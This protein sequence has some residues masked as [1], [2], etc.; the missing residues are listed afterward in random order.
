MYYVL[1]CVYVRVCMYVYI[2]VCVCMYV[3]MYVKI[4][5]KS[6]STQIVTLPKIGALQVSWKGTR[7][8]LYLEKHSQQKNNRKQT[9][10]CMQQISFWKVN[11]FSASQKNI[12]LASLQHDN[13]L[14]RSQNHPHVPVRSQINLWDHAIHVISSY[15]S[16]MHLNIILPSTPRSSKWVLSLRFPHQTLSP[17]QVTCHTPLP[18]HSSLFRQPDSN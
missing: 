9:T 1:V 11:C 15:F 3:R 17:P 16:N 2:Y 18:L 4:L 7:K 6:S 8:S 14:P 10:N 12:F 13:S 5:C